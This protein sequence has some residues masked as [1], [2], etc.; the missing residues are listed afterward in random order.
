MQEE[1]TDQWLVLPDGRQSETGFREGGV[2]VGRKAV[3]L[4]R[5]EVFRVHVSGRSGQLQV[6]EE[7]GPVMD[8]AGPVELQA[9][10]QH[11]G[12][13]GIERRRQSSHITFHALQPSLPYSRIGLGMGVG[14]GCQLGDPGHHKRRL[15]GQRRDFLF[16]RIELRG[17]QRPMDGQGTKAPTLRSLQFSDDPR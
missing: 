9:G 10:I 1:F 11:V 2:Q 4:D 8:T 5:F 12:L 16:E 13:E 15:V 6:S 14:S 7:T 17:Q 3:R